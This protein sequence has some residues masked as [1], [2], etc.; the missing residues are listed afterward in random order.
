MYPDR[1]S[2]NLHLT[3]SILS[4]LILFVSVTFWAGSQSII[5]SLIKDVVSILLILSLSVQIKEYIKHN[6]I[7]FLSLS[8]AVMV[9]LAIMLLT[10]WISGIFM[11]D[12]IQKLNSEISVSSFASNIIGVIYFAIFTFCFSFIFVVLKEFYFSKRIKYNPIYFQLLI[13]FGLLSALSYTLLKDI[14]ESVSVAFLVVSIFLIIKNSVGISWIAFLN[15]K[16]KY[17]LLFISIAVTVFASFLIGYASHDSSSHSVTL[18]SYSLGFQRISVLI[19]VYVLVYFGVLFFTVLFHLPTAEEFDRKAEEVSSLHLFSRLINQVID[20]DELADT[21][22]ELTKKVSSADAS[23]IILKNG[24]KYETLSQKNISLKDI[25]E[26][27]NFLLNSGECKNLTKAKICSLEKSAIRNKLTEQLSSV[28]ISPL[29][30]QTEVKGYILAARKSGL[31]FYEDEAKAINAFSEYASIALENSRLLNESIEK[32]RLEKE[33][34]VARE[35]QRKLLPAFDPKFNELELCSIFIPAFEVGGDFYDYYTENN[36]EFSFIIGDV[37]GKGISAAFVMAEVKGIFE[38]LSRILSSPK[39]ILIKANK[40]LSR[41]LHRKNF[42]SALYGKINFQSSEFEFARAGH[43]PALLIRD[44]QII[45]YQPKGLA[46]GLDF[47]ESF[48]ENLEDIR[49]KLKKNDVLIFYTDGI[50]ESKNHINEDFGE[51]RFLQTIRKNSD[52]AI[53]NIAKEIISEVSL[54]ANDSTQ[55]DDITLLILRWKKN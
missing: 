40:I 13:I 20:F 9:L 25:D 53:T 2:K 4:I 48:A 23:W 3:I 12:L 29:R 52:K 15:K 17:K 54:F 22:T 1:L 41:T 32:E 42:V 18:M 6:K 30:T 26:I 38:S 16:E 31:L 49:L 28:I 14:N 44:G 8:V 43:C 36:N 27:N 47:T 21:I 45:K 33:L 46:L 7:S 37:A 51:E 19:L 35:M 5:I 10:I 39:E 11:D 24:S 50:T 55:Y 34:D